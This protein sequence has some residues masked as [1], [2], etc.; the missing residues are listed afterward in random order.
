ML[1]KLSAYLKDAH[2]PVALLIFGI[3]SAYHFR[4]HL[5]LGANY[6]NTIY[7]TYGFLAGHAYVNR[8]GSPP[9]Q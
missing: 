6:A 1:A 2:V 5:D 8:D 9:A 4:S 3:T 7:A